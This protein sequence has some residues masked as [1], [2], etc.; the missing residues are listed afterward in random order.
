M[1]HNATSQQ[2]QQA[3][4][5]ENLGLKLDDLREQKVRVDALCNS[6]RELLRSFLAK[7]GR[8]R[9]EFKD[10]ITNLERYKEEGA[11]VQA[12]QDR[13]R[14]EKEKIEGYKRRIEEVR[15]KVERHNE[16]ELGKKRV[17]CR[18]PPYKFVHEGVRASS[19]TF[20]FFSYIILGR[21]RLLWGFAALLVIL[22]LQA[23]AGND[24]DDIVPGPYS[25]DAASAATTNTGPI[26]LIP[27]VFHPG[28]EYDLDGLSAG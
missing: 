18:L 17:S 8:F 2:K 13:L 16:M 6:A 4:L 27:P 20:N 15:N 26:K 10:Q 9:S 22:W 25:G 12:L 28:T 7:D 3:E 21:T 5:I 14:A 23:T 24:G 1:A 11:P 19:L